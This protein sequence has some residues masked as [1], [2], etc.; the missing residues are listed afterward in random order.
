MI[1]KLEMLLTDNVSNI[2]LVNVM[3]G[4]YKKYGI[5]IDELNCF[6]DIVTL[7]MFLLKNRID[8]IDSYFKGESED[9]W[10]L[11][12]QYLILEIK[13]LIILDGKSAETIEITDKTGRE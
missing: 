1:N 7:K 2:E 10:E 8:Y 4:N 11:Y 3:I 5:S 13:L 9:S 12:Y 6:N